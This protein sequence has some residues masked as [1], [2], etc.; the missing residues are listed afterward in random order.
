MYHVR[1][2]YIYIYIYVYNII[3]CLQT[4][5]LMISFLALN[6]FQSILSVKLDKTPGTQIHF[7]L[8]NAGAA[9]AQLDV[10]FT[11]RM[12]WRRPNGRLVQEEKLRHLGSNAVKTGC[13]CLDGFE[14]SRVQPCCFFCQRVF[15]GEVHL[16]L[17]FSPLFFR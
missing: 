9:Q 2:I 10:P 4:K 11:L 8:W 7:F 15:R 6:F 16:P 5:M 17:F 1:T 14:N 3:R 13:S 12:P